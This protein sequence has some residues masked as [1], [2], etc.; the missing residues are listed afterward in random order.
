MRLLRAILNKLPF[1][2][3]VPVFVL[4]SILSILLYV[5]LSP[6]IYLY[7]LLLCSKLWIEWDREGKDAL[8][9]QVDSE[10]SREWMSRI[11][12]LVGGRAV[13]LDYSQ[14]ERWDRWSL[15]VQ[16]VA[17]FGPH[18]VPE[19]FTVHSLPA[20]ILFRKLR[21][22]EKFLFGDRSKNEEKIERL[23]AALA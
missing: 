1:R 9:L 5:M 14:R 17:I 21:R 23:R 16:L 2:V 11:L 20:V 12:P 8:I 3:L 13:L 18:G 22:P 10:H 7:G 19:R 4:I 15:S 6:L